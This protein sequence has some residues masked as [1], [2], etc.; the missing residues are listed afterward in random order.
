[1]TWTETPFETAAGGL[2]RERGETA[3]GGLLR[4]RGE[5]AAG[6]L[7]RERVET[8]AGRRGADGRE[9]WRSLK[10]KSKTTTGAHDDEGL[11]QRAAPAGRKRVRLSRNTWMS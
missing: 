8:A 6:G 10:P 4:E 2:L 3:A 9:G 11:R 5:T 1:M 7:L